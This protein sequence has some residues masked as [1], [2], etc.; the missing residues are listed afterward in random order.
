MAAKERLASRPWRARGRVGPGSFARLVATRRREVARQ[1][2]GRDS[3]G[4]PGS[5]MAHCD[6]AGV[7]GRNRIILHGAPPGRVMPNG[8]LGSPVLVLP[9][10][11]TKA[12]SWRSDRS[13]LALGRCKPSR[14]S[15]RAFAAREAVAEKEPLYHL[16]EVGQLQASFRCQ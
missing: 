16:L 13:A 14:R 2:R 9:P 8:C 7:K 10:A 12:S 3:G 15:G 1:D 11:L 5:D 4:I 6:A